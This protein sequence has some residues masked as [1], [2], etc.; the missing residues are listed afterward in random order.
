MGC[1]LDPSRFIPCCPYRWQGAGIAGQMLGSHDF[2]A[3]ISESDLE[4]SPS[5]SGNPPIRDP[6]RLTF[7]IILAS[8]GTIQLIGQQMHLSRQDGKWRL[9]N[10]EFRVLVPA[11]LSSSSPNEWQTGFVFVPGKNEL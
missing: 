9:N 4:I 8:L 6:G 5:S 1:K 7:E 11:D 2:E 10:G 3:W